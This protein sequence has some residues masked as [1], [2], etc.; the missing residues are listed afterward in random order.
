MKRRLVV[1]VF[2]FI[3]VI[4]V[5]MSAQPSPACIRVLLVDDYDLVL[6]GFRL[7]LGQG[8]TMNVVGE[9][10]NGAQAVELAAKWQPDIVLLDLE[11]GR[12]RGLDFLPRILEVSRAKV[13]VYTGAIDE[14]IHSRSLA[15]GAHAVAVKGD[16]TIRLLD[17]IHQTYA[18]ET[19]RFQTE[20]LSLWRLNEME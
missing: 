3:G 2:F 10:K 11:L 9:A 8:A 20:T 16:P 19:P 12:D 18:S 13:I 15:L 17:C 7:L 14:E 4:A 1:C 5:I 6:Q